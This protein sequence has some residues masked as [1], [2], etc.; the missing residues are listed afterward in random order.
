MFIF[1][2]TKSNLKKLQFCT[3]KCHKM[4]IGKKKI[5]EICPD[6]FVDGWKMIEVTEVETGGEVLEEAHIGL[7]TMDEVDEEKYL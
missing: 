2:N 6:L 7:N 4:H 1:I 3:E 5:P